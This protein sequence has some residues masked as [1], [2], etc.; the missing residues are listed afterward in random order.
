MTTTDTNADGHGAHETPSYDDINTPAIV[1]VGA[2][3]A[4]V[5]LLTIMFV[6]GLCYHLQNSY[7]QSQS[8]E[9]VSM[10]ANIQIA[11]QKQV[12]VGGEGIVPIDKAMQS[13]VAKY[14]NN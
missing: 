5:T 12:L 4:L 7:L 11:E 3:S 14:G 1:L 13:I 8:T 9:A 2:I 6:Q 10:P